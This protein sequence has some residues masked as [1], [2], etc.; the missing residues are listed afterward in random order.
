VFDTRKNSFDKLDVSMMNNQNGKYDYIRFFK[1]HK[2][3]IPYSIY[4]QAT[5]SRSNLKSANNSARRTNSATGE[6]R[7]T[8]NMVFT[9]ES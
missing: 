7:A 9:K 5:K 8:K 3:D 4:T 2:K 6:K 1:V